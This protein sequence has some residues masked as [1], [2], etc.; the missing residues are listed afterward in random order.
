[1]QESIREK[2][3][4]IVGTTKSRFTSKTVSFEYC[5][6]GG[7]LLLE[8]DKKQGL[9]VSHLR[10]CYDCGGLVTTNCLTKDP[11]TGESI[12][13]ELVA[14]STYAGSCRCNARKLELS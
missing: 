12:V 4:L 8:Q 9:H 7:P 14:D 6:C 13:L 1:M 3:R 11:H 10:Q 2:I 5:P